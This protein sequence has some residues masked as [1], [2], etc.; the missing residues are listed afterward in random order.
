MSSAAIATPTSTPSATASPTPPGQIL[1]QQG[2]SNATME[3]FEVNPGWQI[4]WRTDGESFAFVVSGE[5]NLGTIVDKKGPASG[6]TS[7]A[8]AG[9]YRIE[10]K[11]VG[12]WSIVVVDGEKPGPSPS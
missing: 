4:T 8:P 12:P 10:I 1:E 9:S 5:Q 7:L 11:A 2:T 3:I 6:V